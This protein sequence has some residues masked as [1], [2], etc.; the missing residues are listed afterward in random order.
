MPN[1]VL[2]AKEIKKSKG[3]DHELMISKD[4]LRESSSARVCLSSVSIK[5]LCNSLSIHL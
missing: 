5:K 1:I 3:R 4:F 2:A